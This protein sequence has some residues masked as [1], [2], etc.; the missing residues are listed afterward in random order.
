MKQHKCKE[1]PERVEISYSLNYGFWT[2]TLSI[3]HEFGTG[4][5]VKIR[6]C[7]FCGKHLE[8]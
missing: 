3:E 7:P 4:I 8:E 5:W 1:M 2:L 6:T